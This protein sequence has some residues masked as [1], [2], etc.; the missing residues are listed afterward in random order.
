MKMSKV[1]IRKE[2][3]EIDV[4]ELIA[5]YFKMLN[6]Q[7]NG[8]KYSKA[9]LVRELMASQGRSKGS[10]ETKLM[11]VTAA[12]MSLNLPD[13]VQGYKALPNY[14]KDL[15]DQILAYLEFSVGRKF[16]EG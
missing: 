14:N 7:G 11:N 15:P 5:L 1:T 9:P 3:S 13:T 6:L 10:I 12:L 4:Q 16:S 2:W 8:I